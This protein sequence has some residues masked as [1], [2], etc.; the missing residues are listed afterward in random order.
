MKLFRKLRLMVVCCLFDLGR[1]R[2]DHELILNRLIVPM[3]NK[4]DVVYVRGVPVILQTHFI[5]AFPL[6][7]ILVLWMKLIFDVP[8]PYF[9]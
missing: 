7:W 3:E 2:D 9:P 6:T 5:P 4:E 8:H 1:Q